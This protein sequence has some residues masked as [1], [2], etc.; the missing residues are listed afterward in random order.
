[1][2]KISW[3]EYFTSLDSLNFEGVDLIVAIA[4]GGIIPASF[5]QQKLKVPMEIIRINY[6]DETHAPL[7]DDARMLEDKP[8]PIRG[9][10][11]LLVDDVSRTGKTLAKAK[12]Y[13]TGNRVKTFVINGEA[14][15]SFFN[16]KECVL[17]P[18]RN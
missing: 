7:Y 13:L 1:M 9:Q 8:F 10:S 12:D 5:I 4:N 17:V 16:Q 15:Y 3:E 6:R 14:D 18:W 2:D 11:I